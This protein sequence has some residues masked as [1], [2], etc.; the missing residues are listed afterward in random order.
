MNFKPKTCQFSC[1]DGRISSAKA[2]ELGILP[3]ILPKWQDSGLNSGWEGGSRHDVAIHVGRVAKT[4]IPTESRQKSRDSKGVH[5]QKPEAREI[6]ND[7]LEKY[8][9]DG[10]LEFSLPDVLKVPPIS[11]HGNVAEII[12]KF[13]GAD[14]LRNAVNQL[15]TL[16][17]PHDCHRRILDRMNRMNRMDSIPKWKT[18]NRQRRSSAAR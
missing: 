18:K 9:T 15:Q 14:Q 8:A 16:L 10:Q 4:R 12:G 13:G 6:L 17:Y 2:I 1:R 7:L 11:H 3:K 5:A